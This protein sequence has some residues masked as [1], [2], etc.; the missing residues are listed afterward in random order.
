MRMGLLFAFLL[1][2][3]QIL[4]Q[5]T[6]FIT[7]QRNRALQGDVL[8][9]RNGD[10]SLVRF[11][12]FDKG[13]LLMNLEAGNY[14]LV[15]QVPDYA[16]RKVAVQISDSSMPLHIGN[17]ILEPLAITAREVEVTAR[18]PLYQRTD[19][20][21]RINVEHT[22]L[23]ATASTTELLQKVPGISLAGGKLFLFGT[24]EALIYLRGKQITLE[25]L[26]SY[27]PDQIQSVEIISNPSARYD[28]NG[29][30]VVVIKL[31]PNDS[32]G[33]TGTVTETA[34]YGRHFQNNLDA[35]L[36][37]QKKKL[38]MSAGYALASGTDW[39]NNRYSTK[40]NT[41]SGDIV[42][43]SYYEEHPRST[44]VAN[45]RFGMEFHPS[46]KTDV[47]LQYDGL[48][49]LFD[50]D[51]RNQ[52]VTN[53]T[54]AS[55]TTIAMRNAAR[56]INMNNALNVNVNHQLDSSGSTLFFGAQYCNFQ[57]ALHDRIAETISRATEQWAALRA[58][59]GSNQIHLITAQLDVVK[60]LGDGFSMAFGAKYA[61]TVNSSAM[62]IRSKADGS[63]VWQDY[64]QYA[65]NFVYREIVPAAYALFNW[66]YQAFRFSFG[67][68]AEVSSVKGFSKKLNQ[69]VFDTTYF[70]FF[71][72][73]KVDWLVTQNWR[74]VW[75]YSHRINRPVYQDLDPFVWYIDS[76]TSIRG[77]SFLRPEL[78]H[79]FEWK[80]SFKNY[81]F[82]LG[83]AYTRNKIWQWVSTG[84]AGSGSVQF[85]KG[86]LQNYHQVN[87]AFD[88]PFES[89]WYNTYNTVALN[90]NVID[91]RSGRFT[92][93][94]LIPQLY[95]NTYHQFM[96]PKIMNVDLSAEFYGWVS[97][98]VGYRKPYYY[99]TLGVSRS[100]LNNQL[101][102]QLTWNDFLFSARNQGYRVQGPITNNFNQ[103]F[104]TRYGRITITYN[105]GHLKEVR[106]HNKSVNEKE[107]NRIKQ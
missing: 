48:Y 83:Y 100:F 10:S 45:Y 92:F 22:L 55:V 66:K 54:D 58:N 14:E 60:Q 89:K 43:N 18:K 44:Y 39:A 47:S 30:A 94:P 99:A 13:N 70:N 84:E 88:I 24:G 3:N 6:A 15:I 69:T 65:N 75:S 85:T 77:N 59:D 49:N 96:I 11:T 86:N 42:T 21:A 28:A 27:P 63:I 102:I 78:T 29:R 51:V 97:D 38:G 50:L 34:T 16:S 106:Y 72:T 56:T 74:S 103:Q 76:L 73:A 95:V 104:N 46:D 33:I 61:H 8:V 101:S 107:F 23:A 32:E 67:T 68:R 35:S 79:S 90:V 20:G 31:K 19:E 91:D 36:N 105:F 52:G 26:R 64:P 17:L 57:T 9:Y 71:P 87:I 80:I 40:T 37:W 81:S 1:T 98:G 2:A 12:S 7:D 5:C 25:T 53:G 82:K 4:A 62:A 93:R 41:A